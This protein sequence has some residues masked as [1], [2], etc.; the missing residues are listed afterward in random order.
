MCEAASI[1]SLHVNRSCESFFLTELK[2]VRRVVW[3]R[4]AEG[5]IS[6][7]F[8]ILRVHACVCFAPPALYFSCQNALA[9]ISL[10][11]TEVLCTSIRETGIPVFQLATAVLQNALKIPLL[12]TR[13]CTTQE[14]HFI[15][16]L[17]RVSITPY[18]TCLK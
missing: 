1:L 6:G 4:N 13:S 15:N 17:L 8:C 14:I 2:T 10:P 12:L 3:L 16:C 18:S 9:C 7:I 11:S 5:I